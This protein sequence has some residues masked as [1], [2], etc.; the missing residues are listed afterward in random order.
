MSGVHLTRI[1]ALLRANGP[2]SSP[3]IAKALDLSQPT[4]SRALSQA[5]QRILRIG[6]ARATRYALTRDIARV[7]HQWPLYR[8]DEAGRA[9]RLGLLTA[10]HGDGYH[11][12]ADRPLPTFMHGEFANGI[13]PGLPWF[14]DIQRPQGF[15]G[16]GFARRVA[17]DLGLLDDLARWQP[18]DILIALLR[19]GNDEGGDLILGEHSM[20]VAQS[21]L[22]APLNTILEQETVAYYPKLAEETLQGDI[23]GSSA[24]GEQPKFAVTLATADGYRPVIVKFSD[25][26]DTPGGRRWADLLQAEAIAGD[27]LREHG[28]DAARSLTLA[29]GDRIFLESTRFDRTSVLGRNGLI[30]LAALDAAYY[31]HGN[32]RWQSFAYEL[33]KDG[34]IDPDDAIKL[35]LLGWFGDLIANNDMHLGNVGFHLCDDR[36][37][38]LAP[39]YDMLPMRFRPSG[40]GEVVPREYEVV[41]PLPEQRDDWHKIAP[42][43]VQFWRTVCISPNMSPAFTKIAMTASEK[44]QAAMLRF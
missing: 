31:G 2:S 24:G 40:N 42:A 25:R 30:Q 41:P 7:G 13:F 8:L 1:E 44:L 27:I 34:W 38:R 4:L 10:L 28:I 29:A 11:F 22:L 20:K 26:I 23:V 5:G 19:H 14:L 35:R 32:I 6:R 39:A 36:P 37:L 12:A 9:E 15:L 16:R 3:E 43:A 21:A 18:D 17:K 33:E